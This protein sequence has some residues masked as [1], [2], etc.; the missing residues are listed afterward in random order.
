MGADVAACAKRDQVRFRVVSQM[1]PKFFMINLQVRHGAALIGYLFLTQ[2]L[3]P[4][5]GVPT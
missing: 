2:W 3:L 1:T 5:L 4:K